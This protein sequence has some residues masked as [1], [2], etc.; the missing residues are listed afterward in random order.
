[1]V[2][3]SALRLLFR[4]LVL[5]SPLFWSFTSKT[6]LRSSSRYIR[7]FTHSK[8]YE[9]ESIFSKPDY[10]VAYKEKTQPA[11]AE[12]AKVYKKPR[13]NPTNE[14]KKSKYS[15][16]KMK[17]RVTGKGIRSHSTDG[18]REHVQE[19]LRMAQNGPIEALLKAISTANNST[20][21]AAIAVTNNSTTQKKLDIYEYNILIKELCDSG[22]IQECSKVLVEMS[23]AGVKR[24][25]ITYTTLISRAGAWQKVQLAEMYFRKM[26]E[27]GIR[28]DAQAYNSLI[29]AY[30]KAGETDRY[31]VQYYMMSSL[32]S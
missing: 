9:I 20:M 1:M 5:C 7:L 22:R 27:D 18:W 17:L 12:Q 14:N 30:A 15:A 6:A 31:S 16:T 8:E 13:Y 26:Q 3:P 19:M 24:N 2:L 11:R 28:A 21:Q 10:D 32:S 23:K 29:N 4:I 25:V